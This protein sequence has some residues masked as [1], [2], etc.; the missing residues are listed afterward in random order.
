[1]GDGA[2]SGVRVRLPASFDVVVLVGW[3]VSGEG[4]ASWLL[5]RGLVAVIAVPNGESFS[6]GGGGGGLG[7]FFLLLLLSQPSADVE[8]EVSVSFLF[9]GGGG[10]VFSF[11][12]IGDW[13]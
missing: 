1:M 12:R 13:T 9:R 7:F 8:G 3:E 11:R 4:L 2:A 10:S 6:G 5:F